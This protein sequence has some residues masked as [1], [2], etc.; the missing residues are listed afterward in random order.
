MLHKCTQVQH[1]ALICTNPCSTRIKATRVSVHHAWV[2]LYMCVYFHADNI[3]G[4]T[5]I[6]GLP[7]KQKGH[8]LN[9]LGF[10]RFL[11]HQN[12]VSAHSGGKAKWNICGSQKHQQSAK[13]ESG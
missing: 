3:V 4:R 11:L 10:Q 8:P 1:E 2:H 7:R 5:L 12:R 9:E 6:L 13:P